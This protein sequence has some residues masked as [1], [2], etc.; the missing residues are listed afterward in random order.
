[1]TKEIV[2]RDG[3]PYTDDDKGTHRST[4]AELVEEIERLRA[5]SEPKARPPL[6]LSGFAGY[7]LHTPVPENRHETAL[8]AAQLLKVARARDDA[9]RDAENREAGQ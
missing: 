2:I 5:A 7:E 6:L 3:Q 8:Y 4:V 9:D 1:M